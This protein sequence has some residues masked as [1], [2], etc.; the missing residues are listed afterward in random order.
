MVFAQD[1]QVYPRRQ[2][3][4]DPGPGRSYAPPLSSGRVGV[5]ARPRIQSIDMPLT[6][7]DNHLAG[8]RDRIVPPRK[9]ATRSGGAD[10]Q[11]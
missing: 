3:A 2:D 1:R 10:E 6:R 7:G 8:M 9:A 11:G 4:L 5:S